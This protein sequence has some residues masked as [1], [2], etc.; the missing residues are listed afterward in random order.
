MTSEPNPLVI[1]P[2]VA[3]DVPA[4]Q[5]IGEETWPRT[6]DFAPP[7]YIASGLATWWSPQSIERS[8]QVTETLV[9]V[10]D[11]AVIGMGNVDL[12]GTSP[13]IWKL[14]VLPEHHGRRAGHLLLEE[15]CSL[16]FRR[17]DH[18]TLSYVEGNDK[19]E[20]FYRSHGFVETHRVP[21]ETPEWPADVCLRRERA[22]AL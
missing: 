22:D 3:D 12:R 4:I 18:V 2:A 11:G 19:A 17:S 1:R 16:A 6:Y 7:E 13:V 5:M 10:R 21:N 9:A 14:Y 15:L 8:L 20:Q